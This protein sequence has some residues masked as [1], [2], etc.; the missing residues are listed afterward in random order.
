MSAIGLGTGVATILADPDQAAFV[1][2]FSSMRVTA[3][4]VR[5]TNVT[6]ADAVTSRGRMA[7]VSCEQGV[8][9]AHG[10]AAMQSYIDQGAEVNLGGGDLVVEV[11]WIPNHHDSDD[12]LAAVTIRSQDWKW[13]S[14]SA[15]DGAA[16]LGNCLNFRTQ[17]SANVQTFE[18]EITTCYEAV[19]TIST[20]YHLEDVVLDETIYARL[21]D[22]ALR[23]DGIFGERMWEYNG[24]DDALTL[25]NRATE[26]L[27]VAGVAVKAVTNPA[28]ALTM[29]L[30]NPIE[31]YEGVVSS[32]N[33]VFGAAEHLAAVIDVLPPEC[34][35]ILDEVLGEMKTST[36]A[37]LHL[38]RASKDVPM[39]PIRRP[40]GKVHR[41]SNIRA[42]GKYGSKKR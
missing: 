34:R 2:N 20:F 12:V 39:Q 9:N 15:S 27:N 30:Q 33:T 14:P 21:L 7:L 25:V 22:D 38:I 28:Q 3:M 17:G 26:L 11:P 24:K 5:V 29:L 41:S 13:L 18:F 32:F 19:P 6:R 10:Y 1:A 42:I 4:A 31:V 16:G 23:R 36:P 37:V 8:P 35:L 40:T